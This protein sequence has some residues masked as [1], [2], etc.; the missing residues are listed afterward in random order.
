MTRKRGRCR[1]RG[2]CDQE[3]GGTESGRSQRPKITAMTFTFSHSLPHVSLVLL[4]SF[5]LSSHR[6]ILISRAFCLSS[7][8]LCEKRRHRVR[9]QL[10]EKLNADTIRCTYICSDKFQTNRHSGNT[11]LF[12]SLCMFT[13]MCD[14]I[15]M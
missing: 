4:C 3:E 12:L 9:K 11:L 14:F 15:N 1:W 10:G 8:S 2:G 13:S 7:F 5:F 6:S